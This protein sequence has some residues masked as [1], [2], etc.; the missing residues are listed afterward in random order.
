M[1]NMD[2]TRPQTEEMT[3][4]STSLS[5]LNPDP[6]R[7]PGPS[8]LH[9]LVRDSSPDDAPALDYLDSDETRM[10]VTY[11]ELHSRSERLARRI[12]AALPQD[13]GQQQLV[14]PVLL[15]QC[16]ELYISQLAIL[17]AGGA[18]C[19]LNLDAPPERVKFIFGDVSAKVVLTST[20]LRSKVTHTE[21]NVTVIA[22]DE[23]GDA[24]NHEPGSGLSLDISPESLAYVMY[25]SG[26]TGTPKGV[27]ISHNAAS[28]ALLAHDRHI[29]SFSRF[30]QFAAPT[31]DVSVFEIFFPMFRGATLVSCSRA[32][33]LNDLPAVIRRLDI[34]ACELTPT[35]AGSL[36]RSR[37]NAP[38][39]RLLLTI[40]EMLT[41]PVIREFG[42]DSDRPSILWA[43]YGPTEATIHCTL[44]PA[45][46]ASAASTNVGFPLDTVS[47]FILE[48]LAEDG[49]GDFRILPFGETGELAVGGHQTAVGYINRQEQTGKAFIDT[50]RGRLYRTGD[51]ARIRKNGTIECFGRISDG[52]VKLR[53]QRIELGEIEQAAL[54]TSGCHGAVAS[55]IQG[56][57]V[58]FCDVDD[59]YAAED[60][61]RQ[62]CQDWLPAFMVPGD[63]VLKKGFP[64][65]PSGKVDRKGLKS[66]Y[67]SL[68]S[69]D[70]TPANEFKDDVERELAQIAEDTLD[71]RLDRSSSLS[72][73]GIDSLTAIKFASRLRQAGFVVGAVDILS[74]K[75]LA[76]LRARMRREKGQ[77]QTYAVSQGG[78]EGFNFDAEEIS[79]ADASLGEHI[80]AIDSIVPCAPM[81]V[82]MLA[83][84]LTNPEAYC[85]WIELSIPACF[86]PDDIES[87]FRDLARYNESMRTGFVMLRSRFMQVIWKDLE[88]SQVRTVKRLRRAFK[89]DERGLLRP[90]DVQILPGKTR[91]DTRVLVQLHHA[92]YDG[93]SFDILVSDLNHLARGEQL[94]DRPKFRSVSNY[95]QSAEFMDSANVARSYWAEYLLGFQPTAMPQ[96]LAKHVNSGQIFSAQRTFEVNASALERVSAQLDGSLQ[97]LFQACLLWLWGSILGTND[98]VIGTVTSGRTLP[99]HGIE[100]VMGPCLTTV[101]LRSRMGQVRTIREFLENIH[102][103]NRESLAHCT[104]PL[105][106]IKKAAGI[107]P[108]QPLYD[109][110]FVYQESIHSRGR[111]SGIV[112]QVAHE[113]YLETKL[114][115]E[116]EPLGKG[117][118]FR[119]TYHADTFHYAYAQLLLRQFE[120]VL[121]HIV[122]HLDHELTSVAGCFSDNLLS[123]YNRTPKT[124]QGCPD[125]AKSFEATASRVPEQIAICFAESIDN[126]GMESQ[127]ISYSELNSLASKIARHLQASGAVEGDVVAIIM[128]KSITLYAGILGILKAGCAYLPLLPSTPLSRIETILKQAEVR[129]CV[130]DAA[131]QNSLTQLDYCRFLSLRAPDLDQQS[132]ENLETPMNPSRI[133]NI[134]YTSG[135]TGIPKGVCVTQLNITSNLDVLSR[136]YPVK[137]D[138]R[139]LQSCSQAFDVSVFEIL[140]ALTQ[141]MCLCSATND[142]LF[143]D[144]ER[145]IRALEVTHLSMTPTVASLVDPASVPKVEFLVTSGEPMTSEVARKWVG[146]L[147]QGYGPSETTNIC[148]VKKMTP[149]DHI[150]HLGYAFENT[151]AFVL[152]TSSN[153][154]MP[155]G[156]V[157]ELCFGGDQVVAGY[158]NLPDVTREKFIAHPKLGRLYRSGDIGRM[159]AD[160][161]LIIVGRID[162]QIKLRGQRIELGEINA[163]VG[164]SGE[165]SN[166]VTMLVKQGGSSVQQLACFYVP[167]STNISQ[168]G[169][170]PVEGTVQRS[171]ASLHHTLTSRLP[172]YMVPSYLVPI[173]TIPMTSSGKVDKARLRN[174][175]NDLQSADLEFLA[176]HDEAGEDDDDWSSKE[177][178]VA[179]LVAKVLSVPLNDIGRWTPFT[180]FGLD[181]IS[182]ISLAKELQRSFSKRV[183]I[184][185]ILQNHSVAKLTPL[186]STPQTETASS[187]NPL[188]IFAPEFLESV[189]RKIQSQG[190]NVEKVLPCTPL[191]EAMLSSSVGDASYLNK[192]LFRLKTDP[193]EMEQCWSAMFQR[194]GILRTCFFSTDNREHAI[195]QVV[196]KLWEPAWLFLDATDGSVD[197]AISKHAESVPAAIDSFTPPISLAMI[198]RDAD[199]YLSFVCHHALYDGVAISRL[200][201][202]IEQ[203][204][205]G[206]ELP[207]A[208]SYE[209]FLSEMLSLPKSTDK[210]WKG[211]LEAL[212]PSSLPRTP[213][214]TDGRDTF[215]RD[216]A[217]SLLTVEE[218]LKSLNTSLLSLVQASWSSV[219]RVVLNSDDVCFGNVVNGRS[220][221]IDRVDELVA[222][223]FNTVPTRINFEDKRRNIDVMKTFQSLNPELLQYQFTPLRRIQNLCSTNGAHLFDTLLLLQQSPQSLDENF[224]IIERDNG[225]MDVSL[226]PDFLVEK[227]L[228]DTRQIHSSPSSAKS[229]LFRPRT[230]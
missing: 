37:E 38:G 28:Q 17:K 159:L 55:V 189:D 164:A 75:S 172:S 199:S 226:D 184:S 50:P 157:G 42:G 210:F 92:L 170:L 59:P 208:P 146:K 202:E 15:P 182:A 152:A 141:G 54:R 27:G 64:R 21:S 91:K 80:S 31:F 39:L 93:W 153:N 73:L 136:I 132:D 98:V 213:K 181:S 102:A 123:Q 117:F 114:L 95:Y 66:D 216:L 176:A 158:L 137:K 52:Q 227:N 118:Q 215:T 8:F 160:G 230:A 147:Y 143:E 90:F 171:N 53:G 179:A 119:L 33:M 149:T 69:S 126:D 204:A 7:L 58:V 14:V 12:L 166:C 201:V 82:S 25:T 97:V 96:L 44:Q 29:P 111:K 138:S 35:V 214:P 168:F 130:V 79:R 94:A 45:C 65:L 200:L 228:A 76:N 151:S 129:I 175:F 209:P 46:E 211:H 70:K 87:W 86:G 71:I 48:P 134:I 142:T 193:E 191:Q 13:H 85:N 18:F 196:L 30:L 4:S 83:E 106:D 221:T 218:R 192:M 224:W 185:G 51:K 41:G 68:R 205:A 115:A 120:S 103:G 34:D 11:C 148:S 155:I 6:I 203:V 139:M 194:H 124:F 89:L 173:S 20:E 127:T 81:Q 32:D 26:S 63:F 2:T 197:A 133:A 84:T 163:V 223:C 198:T 57:I 78:A 3:S 100:D 217:M 195:A 108:G 169:I 47:A 144:L 165:A 9:E 22:V 177:R 219:L 156:C 150:R 145:S 220:G 10:V 110:L 188:D 67:E 128:E 5:I 113:D 116:V 135:S 112:Q 56:I 229:P 222:P 19:P 72:S 40:G 225:D 60:E 62:T 178:E 125:L 154:V 167:T 187:E 109:A 104:L 174:A 107:M 49:T 206:D 207:P 140:F 74:S 131:S 161:S 190:L 122:T 1:D 212:K 180:S 61:L 183:P 101:P 43:M 105:A 162:D 99:I 36:L 77:N 186:L 121:S 16:P 88:D 24:G 23:R